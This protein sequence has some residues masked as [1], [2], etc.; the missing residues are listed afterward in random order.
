LQSATVVTVPFSVFDPHLRTPYLVEWSASVQRALGSRQSFEVS[1]V[2]NR[3]NRLLLTQT[4]LGQNPDF[5][6]LRL[7]TNGASSN[8]RSLQFRFDRRL[9]DDLGAMISYTWAKSVADFGNDTAARALLR[10]PNFENERGP[11][12]FDIRHTLT[13]YVFYELPTPFASG[14][15]NLLTRKW[16]IDSV[17]NVRSA[18][19]VNV[20]YAVPTS[21]GFLYVRPDLIAGVPLY[22]DDPSAA[23][24]KRF[25]PAAFSLPLD[26][27]QGTL[28][29]NALRGFPLTQF[30]VAL[31]RRFNF[32]EDVSLTLGAEADNVFNHPNFATPAGNDA[33]LGTRFAPGV[34]LSV[35]PTFGQTY[36]NAARSS[37]G[38]AGSSFGANYYPGSARTMK[39]S[40]KLE[41]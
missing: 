10:G 1:Y 2:A 16:S 21:F 38:I 25:N 35:N 8:Y 30:N 36:T 24:G 22:L 41:F 40:V 15:R 17:F 9:S 14:L 23:G 19:P 33:S 4:L 28:G 6:F 34:A 31:R 26:L 20:V 18:A 13:G 39:L 12:D 27:R 29:R 37:S 5:N 32:N 7:T 3:G 11:S